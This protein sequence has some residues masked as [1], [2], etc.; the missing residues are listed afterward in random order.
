MTT[1]EK[2]VHL[3]DR[4]YITKVELAKELDISRPTLDSRIN[5]KS[6]WKKLEESWIIREYSKYH[7]S[8]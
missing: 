6:G 7:S 5:G 4:D 3:L 1:T 8:V 2:I